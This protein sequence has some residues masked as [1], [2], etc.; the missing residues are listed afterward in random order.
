VRVILDTNVFLWIISGDRKLSAAAR[1]VFLDSETIPLVSM[2]SIWEMMDQDE[3]RQAHA[4]P[5]PGRFLQEQLRL[6]ACTLLDITFDH[7]VT[8]SSLPFHHKDLFD[9]LIIAQSL[10]ERMPVLSADR[11]WVRLRCDE[12][13]LSGSLDGLEPSGRAPRLDAAPPVTVCDNRRIRHRRRGRPRPL[14]RTGGAGCRAHPMVLVAGSSDPGQPAA[15]GRMSIVVVRAAV[16][17][18]VSVFRRCRPPS[19]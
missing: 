3:L 4:A 5:N 6:N 13:L 10:T 2:A 18:E 14:R 15:V 8:V 12:S 9:R 1:K 19:G 7:C 16:A 11:L 17:A